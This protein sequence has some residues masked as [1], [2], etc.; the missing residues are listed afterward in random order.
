MTM[1]S[2]AR[3]VGRLGRHAWPLA[4]P[5]R[6]CPSACRGQSA[7][8]A[9]SRAP[10]PQE[11]RG[12]GATFDPACWDS[13]LP[14]EARFLEALQLSRVSESSDFQVVV[15][16]VFDQ[17]DLNRD[18]AICRSELEAMMRDRIYASC[19][20]HVWAIT[21]DQLLEKLGAT[22]D[23]V[24]RAEFVAAVERI[25][26]TLDRRVWPLATS[27]F[28]SALMF[29]LNQPLMPLLVKELGIS[30]VQFGGMVA[31]M[32]LV[33][34][35]LA[36]PATSLA[37]H[38][39]R[40]PLTVEG[41][42]V[43]A[44]GFAMAAY[45]TSP[46]QLMLSRVIIGA[47]T[48][49]AGVGQQN[50][51]ADIATGRTRSRVFAPGAMRS[52]AAFAVGPA[53][54]GWLAGVA[55]VQ[56]TYILVGAGMAAVSIRNRYILTE[57]LRARKKA[58]ARTDAS[59]LHHL[60][61]LGGEWVHMCEVFV[62]DPALR[63]VT[64]A[65]TGF[66]FACMSSKFVLLPMLALDTWGLGA[67]QLGFA[68]GAMSILQFA[69]A[70]PA[71]Y[72]ADVHGRKCTLLPGLAMSSSSMAAVTAGLPTELALPLVCGGWAL[73]QSLVG[74]V[75]SAVTLD[76]VAR[77]GLGQK[78]TAQAMAMS[79]VLGDLG[80]MAGCLASGALLSNCGAPAA[81]GVQAAVMAVV[82]ATT[83]RALRHT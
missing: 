4:P 9:A 39:G 42:L 40:K 43:A 75:P 53:I 51:L 70:R 71:A 83:A 16:E 6:V 79:R 54:G 69:A 23:R 38:F 8:A 18:G 60:L 32:P 74:S 29:A 13:V 52:S 81:I 55:G 50:M 10:E 41:Q 44:V 22:G 59:G 30:M 34:V 24:K 33:R 36:L 28:F 25:A 37:N 48:S 45:I 56:A 12:P 65:N 21:P 17:I 47:G 49:F 35:I 77:C 31:L 61:R 66:N 82:T 63:A 11:P 68:M 27:Q 64:F 76:A 2:S 20:P 1:A 46:T 57:T 80:M 19:P 7:A 15:S 26:E 67:A 58:E 73:G 14:F 3:R 62:R 78:E 5:C 72:V